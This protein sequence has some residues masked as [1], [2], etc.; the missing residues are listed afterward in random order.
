M[1][2]KGSRKHSQGF[3]HSDNPLSCAAGVAVLDYVEA[4]NLVD[5]AKRRGEYLLNRLETLRDIDI[6]GDVRGKGL[7]LGIEFV[8]DKETK[9][10]FPAEAGLTARIVTK[11]FEMGVFLVAGLGGC[12]DGVH[13]DQ[14]QISPA[15]VIS[16]EQIDKVVEIMR[17]AI[18]QS[19]EEVS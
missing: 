14:I 19:A 10:P 8:A 18:E 5:A 9:A 17:V 4:N 1:H 7:L 16:E 12:A 13:G 15:L 3:T 2:T 11:A 6:V